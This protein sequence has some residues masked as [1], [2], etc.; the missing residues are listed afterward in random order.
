MPISKVLDSQQD[1]FNSGPNVGPGHVK[2]GLRVTRINLES[3][4]IS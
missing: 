1:F 4:R 2:G 3:H